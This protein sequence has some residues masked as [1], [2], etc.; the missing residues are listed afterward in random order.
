ML[1]NLEVERMHPR[2]PGPCMSGRSNA[3]SVIVWVSV[4]SPALCGSAAASARPRCVRLVCGTLLQ[5]YYYYQCARTTT[6]GLLTSHR[7]RFRM[8][9]RS[10]WLGATSI[11]SRDFDVVS[12]RALVLLLDS[13]PRLGTILVNHFDSRPPLNKVH[14]KH[15]GMSADRRIERTFIPGMKCLFWKRVL[16]PRLLEN[17]HV[18]VLWLF[19][20]DVVT[21]PAT[22]PLAMM[23][24]AMISTNASALQPT[25]RSAGLGTDHTWLRQRPSLSSCVATTAKFV[26]VMTPGTPSRTSRPSDPSCTLHCT[27]SRSTP[28]HR[29]P[30]RTLVWYFPSPYV[31]RCAPTWHA[32]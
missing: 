31:A 18:E 23:V 26:E 24:D 12:Q 13:Y 6:C 10:E 29:S 19:D 14:H 8:A 4:H 17:R 30:E 7:L 9:L 25:I 11:H 32:A 28:W 20:A 27:L 3:D 16:T 5:L 1:A 2:G 22:L 15:V 21:H